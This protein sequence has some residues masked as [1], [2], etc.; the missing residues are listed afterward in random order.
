MRQHSTT[1]RRRPNGWS[2]L[3]WTGDRTATTNVTTV[4]MDR[5]RAVQAVFETSLNLPTNGNG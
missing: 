4:L 2:F 1:G 5:P 3:R